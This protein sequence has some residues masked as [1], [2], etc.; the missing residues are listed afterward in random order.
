MAF[1][2]KQIG[3]KSLQK[4]ATPPAVRP[5]GLIPKRVAGVGIT[6]EPAIPQKAYGVRYKVLWRE[7]LMKPKVEIVKFMKETNWNVDLID[8]SGAMHT[9]VQK[10]KF[11]F[12]AV[13]DVDGNETLLTDLP[14]APVVERGEM[15]G[16]L[17][18]TICKKDLLNPKIEVVK[19]VKDNGYSVDLIDGDDV[20]KKSVTKGD[21]IILEYLGKCDGKK[22][23]EGEENV[24]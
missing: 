7:E 19:V 15:E 23:E 4:T 8:S 20:L 11:V 12:L 17:Y 1:K 24:G 2:P 9:S 16:Q 10:D 21:L 14:C 22:K 3:G 18:L 5:A 13:V 6:S